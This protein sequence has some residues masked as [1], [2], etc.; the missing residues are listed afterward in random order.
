MKVNQ[1]PV[2]AYAPSQ[3]ATPQPATPQPDTYLPPAYPALDSDEDEDDDDDTRLPGGDKRRRGGKKGGRS[4]ADITDPS[5]RP[6]VGPA[7]MRRRHYGVLI[8]FVL[9]V[10]LPTAVSGWYLW[11]RANDQFESDVGFASRTEQ[12]SSPFDFLGAIGGSSSSGAKDMDILNQFITSQDLV[13][14][15]DKRLDLR[16]MFSKPTNDPVFSFAADGTVEDL[17][18]YWQR[19]ID[20]AYDS[21]TGLMDLK[22]Y[23]FDPDDAQKIANA[24]LEESTL[25]INNLADI[26]RE[27]ATRYSKSSLTAAE[28]RVAKARLAITQFRVAN[29]I[30]DPSSDIASQMNVLNTLIQQ[31]A[32]SQIDYDMLVG[33]VAD[34]DPRLTQISRRIAVIKQRIAEEQAKVGVIADATSPGYANLVGAYESLRVDQDFAEKSYLSALAAYDTARTEAQQQD[35][36]LA[37]YVA[38][39]RAEASTAP[40]RLLD[41]IVVALIAFVA[42]TISVL[43]YYALRDRR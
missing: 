38:P 35:R 33:T 9:M 29:H 1:S 14:R 13:V 12:T 41:M 15:L 21:S 16:A 18:V 40:R 42:W 2:E 11:N 39:T 10:L 22:I 4:K 30:L 20:I 37:T 28:D 5:I 32:G 19:M 25:M 26:A 43:I 17:V 23:A 8:M 31:L 24:V 34:N 7:R 6:T 36:Y 3:P 27:D